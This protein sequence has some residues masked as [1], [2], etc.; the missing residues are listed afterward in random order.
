[1]VKHRIRRWAWTLAALFAALTFIIIAVIQQQPIVYA[2]IA[3]II[4]GLIPLIV[5]GW[6]LF[7]PSDS[8]KSPLRFMGYKPPSIVH[9]A[10]PEKPKVIRRP[11]KKSNRR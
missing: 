11:A 9:S 3:A 4:C 5:G 7:S 8:P 1:M 10:G 2:L 6:L